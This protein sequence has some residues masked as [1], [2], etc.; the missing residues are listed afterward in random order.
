[1]KINAAMGT[2]YAVTRT[3]MFSL[4]FVSAMFAGLLVFTSNQ[5]INY[6]DL[7]DVHISVVDG[8]C[9]KV[10][11]YKNGDAYNCQD[12]DVVLRRYHSV[13]VGGVK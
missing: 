11:N 1:M 12:V 13:K 5:L 8:K 10:V 4:I 9:V 3:Q 7:P 2:I 6:L